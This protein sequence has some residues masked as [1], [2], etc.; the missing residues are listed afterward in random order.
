MKLSLSKE[1]AIVLDEQADTILKTREEIQASIEEFVLEVKKYEE[2]IGVHGIYF[3]EIFNNIAS[4][5]EVL[6]TDFDELS[7]KMKETSKLIEQYVNIKP[8]DKVTKSTTV[9]LKKSEPQ[10]KT[11][12]SRIFYGTLGT[13]KYIAF[14]SAFYMS[15]GFGGKETAPLDNNQTSIS[16]IG[17]NQQQSHLKFFVDKDNNKY[18]VIN[19]RNV[20]LSNIENF[21]T[22]RENL[23]DFGEFPGQKIV[24]W[25][26]STSRRRK[27][28]KDFV[29]KIT[30]KR[31][32]I[33]KF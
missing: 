6:L 3:I 13:L 9:E 18:I 14:A 21:N 7:K 1:S 16:T 25:I 2:L 10:N 28:Y 12:V 4:F 31:G 24:D 22:A 19:N 17:S 5:L 15:A 27:Q 32:G 26:P 29:N 11:L 8:S 23:A 20:P 33:N 30:L